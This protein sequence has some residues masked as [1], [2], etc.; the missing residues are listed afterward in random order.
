M[1]HLLDTPFP[2]PKALSFTDEIW[3][4]GKIAKSLGSQNK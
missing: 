2:S 1:S 3:K 4:R